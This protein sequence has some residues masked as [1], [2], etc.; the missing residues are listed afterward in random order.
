MKRQAQYY[1]PRISVMVMLWVFHKIIFFEK[2]C[3]LSSLFGLY[4]PKDTTAEHLCRMH[5]VPGLHLI[6]DMI[7]AKTMWTLSGHKLTF[8]NQVNDIV[9]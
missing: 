5:I 1:I 6:E 9:N 7:K 3:H 8:N 4:S 2:A